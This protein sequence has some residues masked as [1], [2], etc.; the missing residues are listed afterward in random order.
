MHVSVLGSCIELM[1]VLANSLTH[2]T[3]DKSQ[4][5]SWVPCVAAAL[6]TLATLLHIRLSTCQPVKRFKEFQ[7]LDELQ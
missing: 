5:H 2:P 4:A 6:H 3:P 7:R 1:T